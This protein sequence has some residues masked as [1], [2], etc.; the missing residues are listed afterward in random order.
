MSKLIILSFP[1][2]KILQNDLQ[3]TKKEQVSVVMYEVNQL[4]YDFIFLQ[5]KKDQIISK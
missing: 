1:K 3:V 5:M 2:V 4:K